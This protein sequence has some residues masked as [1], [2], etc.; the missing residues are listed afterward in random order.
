MGSKKTQAGI[1]NN[2]DVPSIPDSSAS[3]DI[4]EVEGESADIVSSEGT[5]EMGQHSLGQN[6]HNAQYH[7]VL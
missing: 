4:P 7:V 1:E 5:P 2:S 6:N 3:S